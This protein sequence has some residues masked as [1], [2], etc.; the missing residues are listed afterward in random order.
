MRIGLSLQKRMVAVDAVDVA[1]APDAVV[2]A[3]AGVAVCHPVSAS[4][5]IVTEGQE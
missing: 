5:P 3:H 2:V 4:A 1:S